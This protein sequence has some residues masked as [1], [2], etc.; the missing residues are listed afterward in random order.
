MNILQCLPEKI[1]CSLHSWANKDK[2]NDLMQIIL[3]ALQPRD[4]MS[5]NPHGD[6]RIAEN[7]NVLNHALLLL[8]SAIDFEKEE[9]MQL[10]H[11]QLLKLAKYES[12]VQVRV[13][14]LKCLT[15]IGKNQSKVLNWFTNERKR[16]TKLTIG[17]CLNDKKRVVRRAAVTANVSWEYFQ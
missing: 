4:E 14:S 2:S 17:S 3:I 6:T 10:I 1:R 12:D 8:H 5:N 7:G 9:A 13:N 16:D 11:A 15:I